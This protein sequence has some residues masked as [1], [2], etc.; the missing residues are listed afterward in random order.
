MIYENLSL[1][2]IMLLLIYEFK[3]IAYLSI[4]LFLNL[5]PK[6]LLASGTV[7]A[8]RRFMIWE[9]AEWSVGKSFFCIL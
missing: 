7:A 6:M 8:Y 5:N 2:D 3:K 1:A 9:T 4:H